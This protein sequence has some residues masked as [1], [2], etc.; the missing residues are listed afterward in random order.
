MEGGEQVTGPAA[1]ATAKPYGCMAEFRGRYMSGKQTAASAGR[2]RGC[3]STTTPPGSSP[4][5]TTNPKPPATPAGPPGPLGT[6]ETRTSTTVSPTA[7]TSPAPTAT[8]NRL[9]TPSPGMTPAK[10]LTAHPEPLRARLVTHR[11]PARRSSRP[12]PNGRTMAQAT[13]SVADRRQRQQI[14][15]A[16]DGLI[17][18]TALHSDG[19]LT[20]KSLA[21][22]SQ[23]VLTHR[24]RP[25]GR[26]PR[27]PDRR[28]HR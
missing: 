2:I 1:G 8:S 12:T 5:A 19:K 23:T 21:E 13:E 26:V 10:W 22:G 20:I 7:A 28:H 4:A 11:C 14:R 27:G 18:G 15:D 3:G 9:R 24:H 25:A 6:E 17:A 16:M